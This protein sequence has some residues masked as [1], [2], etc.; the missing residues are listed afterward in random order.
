MPMA[1]LALGE[2]RAGSDVERGKQGGRAVADVIVGDALD[3]AQSHGQHGLG[4]VQGLN[5]ALLIDAQHQGMIG[6]VQI[7]AR[8]CRAPSR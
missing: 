2:D 7:Q 6:R 3:I 8:R 4:A 1:G 5:L